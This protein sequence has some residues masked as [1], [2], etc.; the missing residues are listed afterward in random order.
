MIKNL[1]LYPGWKNMSEHDP[2]VWPWLS[3]RV[4]FN[5]GSQRWKTWDFFSEKSCARN[6]IMDNQ[7]CLKVVIFPNLDDILR[8][9]L[10]FRICINFDF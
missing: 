3:T 6:S 9:F 10:N 2:N 4:H 8:N 5:H 1:I 7:V